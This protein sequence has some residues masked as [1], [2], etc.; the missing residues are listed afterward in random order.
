M[1]QKLLKLFNVNMLHGIVLIALMCGC[2]VSLSAQGKVSGKVSDSSGEPLA[3][4]S[5]VIKGT[6]VGVSTDAGGN[7]SIN[8]T[9]ASNVLVFSL[10]GFTP[11]EITVGSRTSINVSLA[12]G[13]TELEEVVV[14]ALGIKKDTRKVGYAVSSINAKEITK[15][16]TPNFGAAL[17][18]KASGVRIQ[19]STGGSSSSVSV[20]VRGLTSLTGNTQPLLIVDGVPVRNGNANNSDSWDG[21]R[22]YGNGLVDINPEDIESLSI[23]KGAAASAL[24][25]SEAANGVLLVTTKKGSSGKG[26]GVEFNATVGINTVAYMPKVQTTF[27]PGRAVDALI[28]LDD[29]EKE[30]LGILQETWKGN[31]WQRVRYDGSHNYGPRY[32]GR[33]IL[34]WDGSVRKYEAITD[35]PYTD[36]FRTGVTQTYNIAL[37]NSRENSNLRF[38]YTYVNEQ[39]NQYNSTYSKHNFQLAGMFSLDRRLRIDYT[40]NYIR[41]DV[42]NRPMN[43]GGMID[44]M[45]NQFTSFDDIALIRRKAITSLGYKGTR[46][47][48]ENARSL[49]PDENFAYSNPSAAFDYFWTALANQQTEANNRLIASVAPSWDI[50]DG[51]TLR[52]RVST[53]LTANSIERKDRTETP[54]LFTISEINKT[55][56]YMIRNEMYN[57]F[58]G[59]IMLMFDRKLSEKIGLTANIGYQGRAENTLTNQASTRDGLTSENWF[60]LNAGATQPGN[61]SMGKS[62]LLK[63]AVFGSAGVSYVDALYLEATV[64]QEK[65]STLA[66]GKNSFFYPSVNAS[67]IFTDMFK[68]AM[69]KWYDY[70]KL[71]AS[72]GIVG[73]APDI[74]R[75]NIAYNQNSL[76]GIPVNTVPGAIGNDNI[77]PETKYE[78]EFGIE[79]RFFKNRLGFEVSYY[80]NRVED[81]I[82]PVQTINSIGGSSLLQNIGTI[83]NYGLEISL[84]GRPVETRD[85]SWDLFLN[86]GFNRG[87]VVSLADGSDEL[88]TNPS[89]QNMG[90][91][92]K[93]LS[94]VGQQMGDIMTY[95]PELDPATGKILVYSEGENAGLNVVNYGRDNLKKAGNAIPTAVGGFGT[96]LAYKNFFLD[97]LLDF[98]IGGYIVS[99]G[100]Q[101]TMA[102]GINV[103]SLAYRDEKNGGKAYYFP[104]NNT[105]AIPVEVQH[106]TGRG[107][108]GEWVFHDG[109]IVEGIKADANGNSTGQTNDIIVPASRYYNW[110]YN[111]GNSAPTHFTYSVFDNS[112]LKMRELSLGY[113]LPANFTSK[114]GCRNLS[115]SVFGRNLFYFFKNKSG[116]DPETTSGTAWQQQIFVGTSTTASTRTFGF[117]LRASF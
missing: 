47:V 55:G 71:R 62:E 87:K 49:T 51:L 17:Y 107:P 70:G 69:P 42:F 66:P 83:S 97:A 3:G 2:S 45:S 112:Y 115:L 18:G 7:Y 24:Y 106:S 89:N 104:D 41:Q 102:R 36:M 79:S 73:N 90:G 111:V 15:V 82:L 16:G 114:F 96:S 105:Q 101:Y 80:T 39:P 11:Q 68:D 31:T 100:Y 52:G 13:A 95:A 29:Y 98:R 116:Y 37:T 53:D 14:T 91:S 67:F 59:D 85:F 65:T 94:R 8:S 44:N 61:S 30:H 40:A 60:H 38:S 76:D 103:N 108:N 25:G 10:M 32:D 23:L 28:G 5:V 117:S 22:I 46:Y 109:M 57:I 99:D 54:L 92:V 35:S 58:Y 86:Y 77:R 12:E 56:G 64:R 75:A 113:R 48:G 1:N 74:Y 34:Y 43:I 33:D 6:N 21:G 20:T 84:R 88:E 110:T 9:G 19:S 4:V 50:I 26:L 78:W 27:G 93:I 63:T 81:Q 72:Y